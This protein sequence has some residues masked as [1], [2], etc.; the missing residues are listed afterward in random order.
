MLEL[1]FTARDLAVTRLAYSPLWEVV[2]SRRLLTSA[3]ARPLHRRW[4]DRAR[5]R[6]AAAGLGTGLLADL[7]PERGYLP[8]FLNP[9]PASTTPSPRA[10]RAL[11][12]ELAVLARSTPEQIR[13][14]LER[15][16]HWSPAV[17]AFHQDPAA[18]LPHLLAELRGYWEVALAPHW[19]RLR[20]V[21]EGELLHQSRRFAT[22]GPAAV[23]R[24]LHPGVE[25]CSETLTLRH[26]TCAAGSR[27]LSGR[28]LLL[29]PS[30][31][32]GPAKVLMVNRPAEVVQLCYPSRGVGVLWEQATA[33][34]P[35]AVA[36]VLGR[37]RALLLAELAAPAS[38]TELS[39][40]T[41]MS[42]GGIS[43]HLT[44]LRAAGIVSSQRL[45]RSVLYQ[46]TQLAD[47]LLAAAG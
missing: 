3:T 42:A 10:D 33:E 22:E 4:A 47:S 30:A 14:D 1:A 45:G 43:Q 23:L 18:V 31:F 46:R 11:D 19:P 28:G 21:L 13:A 37:S 40:R 34:V 5:P 6:L 2:T 35:E 12:A 15:L 29:V 17:H 8:D 39:H 36:A 24:G 16:E 20:A 38:T 25:W 7:I 41:G 27:E 26:Y 32:V 9:P 44:A